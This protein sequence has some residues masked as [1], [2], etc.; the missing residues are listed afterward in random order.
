MWKSSVA[1]EGKASAILPNQSYIEFGIH[2][3]EIYISN[4]SQMVV[5]SPFYFASRDSIMNDDMLQINK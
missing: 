5:A 1:I 4:E 3:A 2:S